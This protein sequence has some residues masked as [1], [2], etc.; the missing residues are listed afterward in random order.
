M[1]TTGS[2]ASSSLRRSSTSSPSML[3]HLDVEE[4]EVGRLAA[5]RSSARPRRSQRAAL[6]TLVLEDHLQ[7]RADGVLVVDDQHAWPSRRAAPRPREPG[8]SRSGAGGTRRAR[9]ARRASARRA[10]ACRRPRR[11]SA[12]RFTSTMR[13]PWA[14]V[15]EAGGEARPRRA[16]RRR[17][18]RTGSAAP[19]A[20]PASGSASDDPERVSLGAG[21]P[22]DAEPAGSLGASSALRSSRRA[23]S[24]DRWPSRNTVRRTSVPGRCA[25]IVRT[26]RSPSL[27]RLARDRR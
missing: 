12:R 3:R 26:S 21:R 24:V 16:P 10:R 1:I 14:R 18:G 11:A 5:R 9:P 27:D 4:H 17:R 20:S 8:T 7:R 25:E 15:V 6:V 13:S 22:P 2:A 19:G 23:A